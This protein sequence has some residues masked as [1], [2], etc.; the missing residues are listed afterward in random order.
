MYSRPDRKGKAS[1][2][3]SN[4]VIGLTED[5]VCS[6]SARPQFLEAAEQ[7]AASAPRVLSLSLCQRGIAP[8]G[9]VRPH[10]TVFPLVSLLRN[11]GYSSVNERSAGSQQYS[12][13]S[14]KRSEAKM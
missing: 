1:S 14:G 3:A 13:E 8:P 2:H 12:I 6:V 11:K 7:E 5:L 10:V 9:P 4:R